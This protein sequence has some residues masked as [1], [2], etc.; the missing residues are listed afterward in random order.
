MITDSFT[1]TLGFLADYVMSGRI[2]L[3]PIQGK[4]KCNVT[5]GKEIYIM[6]YITYKSIKLQIKICRF[7]KIINSEYWWTHKIKIP[8]LDII[9]SIKCKYSFLIKISYLWRKSQVINNIQ[10]EI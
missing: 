5:M 10:M 3:L 9:L 6:Q 4:G 2:L 8:P 1:P 7:I